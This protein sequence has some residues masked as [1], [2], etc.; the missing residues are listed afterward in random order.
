MSMI[1][2]D[3]RGYHNDENFT[4]PGGT[5]FTAIQDLTTRTAVD[6]LHK[7][8]PMVQDEAQRLCPVDTGAMRDSIY[9]RY[10]D[11]EMYAEIGS[12][13]PAAGGRTYLLYVN[14]GYHDRSGVW[15]PGKHFLERALVNIV[16]R[17]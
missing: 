7:V 3:I 5:F 16:D 9:T 17:M 11:A 1:N 12:D 15:H 13:L 8:A 2:W 10:N 6:W 14:L 4:V